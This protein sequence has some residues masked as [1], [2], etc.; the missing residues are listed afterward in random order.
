MRMFFRRSNLKGALMVSLVII[1][2]M[3]SFFMMPVTYSV[4]AETYTGNTNYEEFSL[5][6]KQIL[7][8]YGETQNNDIMMANDLGELEEN[9]S[10]SYPVNRLIVT[11]KHKLDNC[12]AIASA[13]Y[14][15]HHI[16]QYSNE[17]NAEEAYDYYS[18]LSYVENVTYDFVI[19]SNDVEVET[20]TTY[21]YKSWGAEYVG[22]GNYTNTLLAMN[23]FDSL[24]EVVVAVIDS[25]IY[26]DHELFK[27]RILTEYAE[28][29]T[30]ETD[31]DYE[32][33]DLN[34]HGT[35]VSGT[36]AEATLSNVKILPLKVLIKDG[37]GW[38]SSMIAAIEKLIELKK[39]GLNIKALNMSVGI[40][41]SSG[42][43]ST[44][45]TL[46]SMI[47][48][49]Y[50]EGIMSVVSAGNGDDNQNPIDASYNSPANVECAI[51][52]AAVKLERY[53]NKIK[54]SDYSNYGSYIDLAAPG[55][56]IESAS[57]A[58]P[59]LYTYKSGTSM[60]TPHV[61]AC[62]ALL[63]SNPLYSNYSLQE[64]EN[65][66][67]EN[68]ID[69][70]TAGWDKLYGY[71]LVNISDVGIVSNG[72]VEFGDKNQ[73]HDSS[74]DLTL[75]YDTG[76]LTDITTKI[77]YTTDET[78]SIVDTSATLYSSPLTI[79]K[80]TKVSAT[81]FV[82]N[83]SGMLLQKSHCT[84]FTYYFD[85]MDLESNYEFSNTFYGLV[86]T[87]YKGSLTTLN[88]PKS[89]NY[90]NIIGISDLAFKNT[91]VEILNLPSTVYSLYDYAFS[92]NTKLKE[93][94]CSNSYIQIGNYAFR[95]CANLE[96]LD[97]G[98]IISVGQYAFTSCLKL[99][100]LSLPNVTT[101]GN[102]AFTNSGL[103]SVLFGQNIKT[104]NN[105]S[106]LN[107]TKVYGYSGTVAQTFAED[108]NLEFYDLSLKFE[109]DLNDRLIVKEKQTFSLNISYLGYGTSYTVEF[110]GP[111]NSYS[112]SLV[113]KND[114]EN[115]LTI[116]FNNLT[117]GEFTLYIT[118]KD[119]FSNSLK[120]NVLHI[121]VVDSSVKTYTLSYEDGKY[122]VYV[123]GNKVT[124]SVLL[125]QD[126]EYEIEVVAFSGYSLKSV[127]VNNEE[128]AIGESFK[129]TAN[130]DVSL[131]VKTQEKG[132]LTANFSITGNGIV[133]VGTQ[134]VSSVD[135]ERNENLEFT[136][137]QNEGYY[138]KRVEVNGILLTA[139]ENGKYVVENVVT[140]LDIKIVLAEEYYKIN[141]SMGK[142]GNFSTSGGTISSVAYGSSRTFI[143]STNDG[144]T[145]DCVTVNGQK[146]ELTN[147]KFTLE[148]ISEDYEIV[149]SFKEEES[150]MF[151]E[152]GTVILG[153]LIVFL[154]IFV[155]FI[156]AK[157]VLYLRRK[158][159]NR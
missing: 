119:A 134:E 26:K 132:Q 145:I 137:L 24:P 21:T 151:S 2:C 104:I 69:L 122:L 67:K 147:N 120:S 58:G 96:T 75:T 124:S 84:S 116:V 127:S 47:K 68:A 62:V 129:L 76:D 103:K 61:T 19:T 4:N 121:D 98:N 78:V 13:E 55:D 54:V 59:S 128:K 102:H 39:S 15:Q 156:I 114:F 37:T 3:F 44:I 93:I 31:V 153:Y 150:S 63:Y 46:S 83:S 158:E 9:L 105:Q 85:N 41:V 60:A 144:Y 154:S 138:I 97:F 64:I 108:N 38:G 112:K 90:K 152:S 18:K 125:Y 141:V 49:A 30:G 87:K 50:N 56:D 23:H 107:L 92:G 29:Y 74:F 36:I 57:I 40:D 22:Y 148:N 17:E 118:I 8:E 70:G 155:V 73:F 65:I 149:V 14:K 79:L 53:T 136:I 35:H 88:V 139:N 110:D 101:I 115:Q 143:I 95:D 82:Y 20:N 66:L 133:V 100:N 34:G 130:K 135:V 146:I 52:V 32:Y 159:N 117:K 16:F 1:L 157:T 80:T 89:I 106:D 25:G 91:D 45:K 72:Y 11:A 99:E 94:H 27:D 5:D 123:D 48:N 86:I 51:T 113:S 81:A 126:F 109:N 7:K 43:S 131:V 111:N 140:D 42:V 10:N 33:Q 142:G 77:Y 12:G 6:L 28:D 71:G